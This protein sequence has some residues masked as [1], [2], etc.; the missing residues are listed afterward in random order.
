[1][2]WAIH[3]TAGRGRSG[4]SWLSGTGSLTLSLILE[5]DTV[6]LPRREW[7]LLSLASGMA[8]CDAIRAFCP[9]GRIGVKWPND[10]YADG[11][12]IAGILVETP[13]SIEHVSSSRPLSRVVVGI[14]VNVN[15]DIPQA[16][17]SFDRPAITMQD[18]FPYEAVPLFDFAKEVCLRVFGEL[19][20][21][22]E[23]TGAAASPSVGERWPDYCILTDYPVEWIPPETISGSLPVRGICEGITSAG[24]LRIRQADRSEFVAGRGSVRLID[25]VT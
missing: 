20:V 19:R 5:I 4:K 8:V 18:L 16:H 9:S 22:Q 13:R 12:K 3:Q 17:V 14:G 11:R 6:I 1:V 24:E 21:I 7:S 10:V 25:E 23:S 15:N 2:I